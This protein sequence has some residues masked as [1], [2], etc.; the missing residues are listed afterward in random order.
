ML[1]PYGWI[2]GI[3]ASCVVG[4]GLITGI[5]LIIKSKKKQVARLWQLG[6]VNI[7][8]G[9]MFLGVFFDFITVLRRG[10][11]ID[12]SYGLV[13]LLSYV[14]YPP[15]TIFA[16]FLGGELLD[17]KKNLKITLISIQ[18]ALGVAFYIFIFSDPFRSFGF[19][20]PTISGD[21]LIDYNIELISIAGL[22]M[23][24]QLIPLVAILGID[25]LIQ[26]R[27]SSGVIKKKLRFLAIGV[28]CYG[29]FGILEGLTIPGGLLIFVR[30]GYISSFIF[31]YLGL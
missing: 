21:Y 20:E 8:G 11:N 18:I 17:L 16:M 10:T 24:G 2:D 19:T 25:V 14:F 31:M 6:I 5:L 13:G 28:F 30:I 3:T 27:K 29:I 1:S 4:F 15:L 22:L 12:N 9:L 23:A 7:L 26:S